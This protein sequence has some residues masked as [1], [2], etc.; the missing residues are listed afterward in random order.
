M[1][2]G[3][4]PNKDKIVNDAGFMH[5]IIVPVFIPNQEDYFKNS[6]AIF[7]KCIE[8]ILLTTNAHYTFITIV[9]NGSCAEVENFL[10]RLKKKGKYRKSLILLI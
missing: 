1:R 5:Q 8:S 6:Y 3:K 10:L 4:N 9:N 7:K 2:I